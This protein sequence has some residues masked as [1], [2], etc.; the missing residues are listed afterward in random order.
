MPQWGSG[1]RGSGIIGP[2]QT[3][4]PLTPIGSC[5][6]LHKKKTVEI[7]TTPTAYGAD[8][9]VKKQETLPRRV[10]GD[11]CGRRC[12]EPSHTPPQLSPATLLGKVSCFFTSASAP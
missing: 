11:S 10:A 3:H 8:A 6:E 9:E 1:I 2:R 7:V 12:S 4:P 5:R